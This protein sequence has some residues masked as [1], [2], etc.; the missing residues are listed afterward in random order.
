MEIALSMIILS[1]FTCVYHGIIYYLRIKKLEKQ[2]ASATTKSNLEWIVT[3]AFSVYSGSFA[4]HCMR[5]IEV[6]IISIK[7][8]AFANILFILLSTLIGIILSIVF[9]RHTTGYK[10]ITMKTIQAFPN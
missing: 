3:L 1:L 7:I 2:N 8:S 5:I 4:I 10:S 9:I 6:D